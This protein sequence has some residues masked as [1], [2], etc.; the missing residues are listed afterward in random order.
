MP[1]KWKA[2]TH[3]YTKHP[4]IYPS[5]FW[6]SYT[7]CPLIANKNIQESAISTTVCIKFELFSDV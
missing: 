4:F 5:D 2:Y 3:V 6:L 1:H 7:F